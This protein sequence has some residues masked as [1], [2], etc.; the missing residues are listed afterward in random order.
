M[1]VHSQKLI[2]Q[3]EKRVHKSLT[4]SAVINI[5]F[6]QSFLEMLLL[7]ESGVKSSVKSL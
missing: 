4:I 5:V 3:E 1:G 2:V 6:H 7:I